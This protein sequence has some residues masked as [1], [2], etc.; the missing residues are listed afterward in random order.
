MGLLAKTLGSVQPFRYR[1]Y[2]FDEE[3]GLYY[4]ST[5]FYSAEIARFLS[6]DDEK[7]LCALSE[8]ETGNLFAYCNN[9]PVSLIDEEGTLGHIFIGAFAGALF[10]FGSQIIDA[11]G[12]LS[13]VKWEKVA[14]AAVTGGVRAVLHPGWGA[15]VTAIGNLFMEVMDGHKD[16]EHVVGSMLNGFITSLLGAEAGKLVSKVGGRIIA[17]ILGKQAPGRIKAD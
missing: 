1:G 9:N 8:D 13:K 2:V 7:V 4:V 17:K 12:D 16:P 15:A 14:M 6:S 5:R 10:E 11:E 3:T